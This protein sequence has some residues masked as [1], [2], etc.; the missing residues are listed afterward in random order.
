[1]ELVFQK[2]K[3]DLVRTVQEEGLRR[4]VVIASIP[5]EVRD[6]ESMSPWVLEELTANERAEAKACLKRKSEKEKTLLRETAINTISYR[7]EAATLAICENSYV[8]VEELSLIH[9]KLKTLEK[10]VLARINVRSKG[11][12][13]RLRVAGRSFG[14]VCE[15][16]KQASQSGD[17]NR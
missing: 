12:I 5:K 10:A 8:A 1:M 6:L 16:L 11:K 13:R 7:M 17:G 15:G 4:K 9:D 3:T 14:P 2:D